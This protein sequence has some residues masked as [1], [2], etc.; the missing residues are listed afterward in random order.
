VRTRAC[1]CV[2]TYECVYERESSCMY[3]QTYTRYVYERESVCMYIHIYTGYECHIGDTYACIECV[4]KYVCVY[5][6]IYIHTHIHT[7]SHIP[8]PTTPH[9]TSALVSPWGK[10]IN[11]YMYMLCMYICYNRLLHGG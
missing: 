1:V 2:C 4:N 3:I 9:N 11:I 7:L 8:D 6:C 10:L 5:I